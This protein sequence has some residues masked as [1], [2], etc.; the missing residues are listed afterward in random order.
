MGSSLHK[1]Y[2]CQTTIYSSEV[3]IKLDVNYGWKIKKIDKWKLNFTCCQGNPKENQ[4]RAR[5]RHIWKATPTSLL[6]TQPPLRQRRTEPGYLLETTS[7][8]VR[9]YWEKKAYSY[10]SENWLTPKEWSWVLFRQWGAIKKCL[11]FNEV[12][13]LKWDAKKIHL[14]FGGGRKQWWR[15]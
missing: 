7:G 4:T 9:A 11:I 12:I 5:E 6:W 10:V 8:M 13:L 15:H 14:K 2:K 3:N 1:L